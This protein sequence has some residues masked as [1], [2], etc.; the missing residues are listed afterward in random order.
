MA[1]LTLG[2]LKT[3]HHPFGMHYWC[4][5]WPFCQKRHQRIYAKHLMHNQVGPLAHLIQL[6][7]HQDRRCLE[8]IDGD[9]P[10]HTL[11]LPVPFSHNPFHDFAMGSLRSAP[12]L[13][14][15]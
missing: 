12:T 10:D 2:N 13:V 7:H 9:H 15:P 11:R 4:E 6:L 8:E 1:L 5:G 14:Y 3:R